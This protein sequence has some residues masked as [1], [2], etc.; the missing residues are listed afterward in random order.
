MSAPVRAGIYR[1]VRDDF[2][3]APAD[4]LVLRDGSE[5]AIRP[6]RPGDAPLV[7]EGFAE[8]SLESRRYR[9]LAFK[10]ALSPQELRYSTDVDH[11]DHEALVAISQ[12]DGRGVGI[13]SCIRD[14]EHPEDA[15]FAITVVDALQGR[16]LGAVLLSRLAD[17][18]RRR[19]IRRF[20]A[21]VAEDNVA[22]L[23][24]LTDLGEEARLT[25]W[26]SGTVE[27]EVDLAPWGARDELRD[28][29]RS[30][31]RAWESA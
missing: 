1:S 25:R 22:M 2:A 10:P 23:A 31:R 13:A 20:T 5:V 9:F 8:L 21:L 3:A 24:L 27:Y 4:R 16:G 29:W 14:A 30:I 7:A 12:I 18:A 6:V 17:H 11:H 15:E 28:L 26:G 19:G